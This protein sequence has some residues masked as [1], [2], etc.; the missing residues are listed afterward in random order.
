MHKTN[1]LTM[2]SYQ[3]PNYITLNTLYKNFIWE[4]VVEARALTVRSLA[5][6]P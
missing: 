1:I 3:M 4:R 6:P 5:P 2:F